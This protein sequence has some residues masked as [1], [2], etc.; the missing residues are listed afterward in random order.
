MASN[1][2]GVQ[3][4]I[5]EIAITTSLTHMAILIASIC[6]LALQAKFRKYEILLA[7]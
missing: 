7:L 2:A 6:V 5:K 4:K 1:I 3:A